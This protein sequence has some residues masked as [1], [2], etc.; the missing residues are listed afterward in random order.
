MSSAKL[1]FLYTKRSL[2][3]VSCAEDAEIKLLPAT[4][5]LAV[6]ESRLMIALL[7]A[8]V[9][10]MRSSASVP[11]KRVPI[12]TLPPLDTLK[13]A[14]L[15]KISPPVKVRPADDAR[16]T[17]ETPPENEEVAVPVTLN[18]PTESVPV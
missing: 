13:F 5:I 6:V 1:E 15:Y 10:A 16:P 11:V 4:L 18:A 17:A 3:K 9:S 8:L 12:P 14:L 2:S 7:S